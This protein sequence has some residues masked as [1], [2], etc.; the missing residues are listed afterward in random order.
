MKVFDFSN[1]TKGALLGEV[2]C[3]S[4]TSGYPSVTDPVTGQSRF[5]RV[6][7]PQQMGFNTQLQ[8]ST[9]AGHMDTPYKPEDFGVD[10]ILFC[11][12]KMF[13][14]RDDPGTWEWIV[15]GTD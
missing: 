2:R 7:K 5:L 1:G 8:V 3:A 13:A 14:G 6:A 4:Y 9:G 15:V 12:G 11:M 10:A